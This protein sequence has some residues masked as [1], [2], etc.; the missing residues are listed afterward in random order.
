M[1][2]YPIAY[3]NVFSTLI[4]GENGNNSNNVA[5]LKIRFWNLN[6]ACPNSM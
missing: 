5:E 1:L 2:W 6:V 4:K 3:L